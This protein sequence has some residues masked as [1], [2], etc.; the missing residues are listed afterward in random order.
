MAE[1]LGAARGRGPSVRR[2]PR[3][4]TAAAGGRGG[5]GWRELGHARPSAC[6]SMGAQAGPARH[7][8][9]S[10]RS[11]AAAGA[12][13]WSRGCA[14]PGS[15]GGKRRRERVP[16]RSVSLC[17]PRW[18]RCDAVAARGDLYAQRARQ[19]EAGRRG[20]RLLHV[21]SSRH[22]RSCELDD[23]RS[24]TEH[25][26]IAIVVLHSVSSSAFCGA[27]RGPAVEWGRIVCER[28]KRQRSDQ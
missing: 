7:G 13:V 19:C 11:A 8:C 2:R 22:R 16:R 20:D 17:G 1:R 21:V 6:S 27:G 9:R 26:G 10:G 18:R 5:G 14:S 24:G 4:L 15:F 28:G 23:S 25:R 12:E 3:L